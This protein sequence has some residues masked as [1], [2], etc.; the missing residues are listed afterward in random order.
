MSEIPW[1]AHQKPLGLHTDRDIR[2]GDSDSWWVNSVNVSNSKEFI[3]L[4]TVI[5]GGST[6][7]IYQ[8]IYTP[9]DSDS[10]GSTMSLYQRI[11]TP[12]DSDSWWVISVSMSGVNYT[13]GDS[14]SWWVIS[15]NVSEDLY[16]R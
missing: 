4:V 6:V 14:D 13:P 10:G 2:P 5:H 1:Y 12:G 11:Y 3:Q 15:V 16:T 8:K 9:S 7:S